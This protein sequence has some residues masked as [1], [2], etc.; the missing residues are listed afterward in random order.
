M[1]EIGL[2]A[3]LPQNPKVASAVLVGNGELWYV[4]ATDVAR[5]V[6]AAYFEGQAPAVA[7]R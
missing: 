6:L 2:L 5:D 3:T 1:L 7:T 4:R